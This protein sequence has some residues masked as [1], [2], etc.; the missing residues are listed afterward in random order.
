MGKKES[1]PPP[2]PKKPLNESRGTYVPPP[3]ALPP[4]PSLPKTSTKEQVIGVL[5]DLYDVLSQD[6]A[7]RVSKAVLDY[8]ESLEER[9]EVPSVTPRSKS[10][11]P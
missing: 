7:N 9:K 10:K 4:P 3:N 1:N 11:K 8:I 2:P 5:G 6:R